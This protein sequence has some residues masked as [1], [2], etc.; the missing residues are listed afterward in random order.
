MEYSYLS[1]VS[2]KYFTNLSKNPFILLDFL[3]ISTAF[4]LL[5]S[6]LEEL[7]CKYRE[8]LPSTLEGSGVW[9]YREAVVDLVSGL[10]ELGYPYEGEADLPSVDQ[11]RDR[12]EFPLGRLIC[13]EEQLCEHYFPN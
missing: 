12:E 11:L 4:L 10:Q 1:S 9:L 5:T 3:Y 13:L 6:T 8:T 7:Y 2:C